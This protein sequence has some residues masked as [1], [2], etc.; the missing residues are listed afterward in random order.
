MKV[1]YLWFI[2]SMM[3]F[4]VTG[5]LIGNDKFLIALCPLVVGISASNL[6]LDAREKKDEK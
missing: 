1:I 4:I 5:F 2:V 3:S 6:Y